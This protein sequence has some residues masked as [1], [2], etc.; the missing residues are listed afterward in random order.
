MTQDT[1]EESFGIVLEYFEALVDS[2]TA[3]W[4]GANRRQL[5]TASGP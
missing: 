3:V 1:A 2:V 4:C 5:R